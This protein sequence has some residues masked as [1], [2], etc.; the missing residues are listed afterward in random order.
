MLKYFTAGDFDLS[1]RMGAWEIVA[2]IPVGDRW[3]GLGIG[4]YVSWLRDNFTLRIWEYQPMPNAWLMIFS[5]IGILGVISRHFYEPWVLSKRD[6]NLL[7]YLVDIV[8]KVVMPQIRELHYQNEAYEYMLKDMYK[9]KFK[10]KYCEAMSNVGNEHK[11]EYVICEDLICRESS[12]N[13]WYC[14]KKINENVTVGVYRFDFNQ[15]N[16]K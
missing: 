11:L 6:Y 14:D 9:D 8:N 1:S 16:Q 7:Y 12:K 4:N 15:N 10:E 5:E 2:K 3:L 13:I